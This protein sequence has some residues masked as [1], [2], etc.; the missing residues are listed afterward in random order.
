MPDNKDQSFEINQQ[1]PDSAD[2]AEAVAEMQS[3]D[4]DSALHEV[5]IQAFDRPADL[6]QISLEILQEDLESVKQFIEINS[7]NMQRNQFHALTA[8]VL[9][10][11]NQ[12]SLLRSV[13]RYLEK[14]IKIRIALEARS[15]A[16]QEYSDYSGRFPHVLPSE[17]ETTASEDMMRQI[18]VRNFARTEDLDQITLDELHSDYVVLSSLLRLKTSSNNLQAKEQTTKMLQIQ[19][20]HDYVE[21]L[22]NQKDCS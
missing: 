4:H 9:A 15:P 7:E 3:A 6:E 17:F 16:R 20:L 14:V 2:R 21:S 11:H 19:R 13:R 22:V 10:H 1:L 12:G 18:Y 5:Y 8:E